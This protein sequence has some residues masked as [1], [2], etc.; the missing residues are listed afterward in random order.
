MHSAPLEEEKGAREE[1]RQPHPKGYPGPPCNLLSQCHSLV[2]LF[3]QAK[4]E[5]QLLLIGTKSR[6][7][8]V[9]ITESGPALQN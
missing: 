9:A 5:P 4:P 1:G 7:I 3:H 6:Q 8:S 2:A